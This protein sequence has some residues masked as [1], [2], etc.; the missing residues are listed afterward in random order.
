[1]FKEINLM[2]KRK[3]NLTPEQQELLDKF[4]NKNKENNENNFEENQTAKSSS[5]GFK[6]MVNRSGSRGK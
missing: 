4:Q 3:T 5:S 1:M 6:P 2:A